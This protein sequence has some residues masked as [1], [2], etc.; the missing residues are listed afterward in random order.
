MSHQSAES[1][2]RARPPR[3]R[4]AD[5]SVRTTPSSEI[6]AAL[7]GLLADT[8]ALYVKTKNFHWH[9]S[10]PH[11]R[12]YHLLLDEQADQIEASDR[13]PGRA[14]PQD[15]RHHH[16]LDRPYHQA[17]ARR[18]TTTRTSSLPGDMLCE[19][20][21][22]NKAHIENMRKAHKLADDHED[23]ATASLLEVF[24]DE[25]EKRCW[26]LFEAS[27][28]EDRQADTS[29]EPI[30]LPRPLPSRTMPAVAGPLRLAQLAA[31][32]RSSRMMEEGDELALSDSGR[33]LRWWR[34]ALLAGLGAGGA[35]A[36]LRGISRRTSNRSSCTKREGLHALHR[37]PC[38][39]EQRDCG[40]CG[41]RRVPSLHR[42]AVAQELRD[43]VDGSVVP[44]KPEDSHLLIYPLVPQEGGAATIPAA[45]NGRAKSDPD[46][47]RPSRAGS[48]DRSSRQSGP[49]RQKTRNK[50]ER[51]RSPLSSFLLDRSSVAQCVDQR[52]DPLGRLADRNDRHLLHRHSC[53]S[54]SPNCARRWRRRSACCRA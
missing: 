6:S 42:G 4:H 33:R 20:M 14:R 3:A 2:N 44:G 40:W 50:K 17:A 10:G 37:V 45:G 18:R 23:V 39:R 25:A 5:R 28:G 29:A 21:A 35:D 48:T 19:L 22:D 15:R 1:S 36:R 38:G 51:E 11:F 13:H 32:S 8:F 9:V 54:P 31:A 47:G 16:P 49:S 7:N 43:G 46:I 53:R 34:R 24:I 26:F 52:A 27:R 41:C 30:R 12:D